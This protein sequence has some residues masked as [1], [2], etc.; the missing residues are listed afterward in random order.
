MFLSSVEPD[1]KK[2]PIHPEQICATPLG[3]TWFC[4]MRANEKKNSQLEV[5]SNN[6]KMQLKKHNSSN[7]V[8][9]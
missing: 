3:W 4:V 5:G 2:T 6:N 7:N 8:T 1:F 9:E